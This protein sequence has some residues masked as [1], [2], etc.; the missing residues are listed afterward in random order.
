MSSSAVPAPLRLCPRHRFHTDFEALLRPT[1]HP[2][3]HPSPL[4]AEGHTIDLTQR[5]LSLQHF[6]DGGLTQ[7]NHSVRDGT[8]PDFRQWSFRQN[9]LLDLIRQVQKFRNTLP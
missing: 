4:L 7:R 3:P 8:I 6:L 9:H 1:A 5:G 2:S